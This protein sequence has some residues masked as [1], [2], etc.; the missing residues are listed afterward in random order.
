MIQETR[1]RAH[2]AQG[3]SRLMV[4]EVHRMHLCKKHRSQ[5]FQLKWEDRS[6]RRYLQDE[7][8]TGKILTEFKEL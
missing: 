6:R 5:P 2:K 3:I 8:E 7:N 1:N 4:K